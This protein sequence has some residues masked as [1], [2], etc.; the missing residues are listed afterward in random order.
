MYDD[1][2]FFDMLPVYISFIGIFLIGIWGGLEL[3]DFV[4]RR[5]NGNK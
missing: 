5:K 3:K 2:H 4:S 1:V